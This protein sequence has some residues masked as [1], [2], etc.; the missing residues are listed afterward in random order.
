VATQE[1]EFLWT[2][3]RSSEEIRKNQAELIKLLQD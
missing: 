2:Q 3:L 1:N